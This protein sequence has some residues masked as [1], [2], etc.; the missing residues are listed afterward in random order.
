MMS[1]FTENLSKWLS[2]VRYCI[3]FVGTQT[4]VLI[5]E[6]LKILFPMPIVY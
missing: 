6:L 5:F 1:L 4:N 3:K 2:F